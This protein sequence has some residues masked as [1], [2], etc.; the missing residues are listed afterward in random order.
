M[1]YRVERL[2]ERLGERELERGKAHDG[3]L[4]IVRLQRLLWLSRAFLVITLTERDHSY[5]RRG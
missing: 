3:Y 2:T 1:V 5:M 4:L